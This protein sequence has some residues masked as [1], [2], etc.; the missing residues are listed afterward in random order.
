MSTKFN[1]DVCKAGFNSKYNLERHAGTGKC[2][3]NLRELIAVRSPSIQKGY[4]TPVDHVLSRIPNKTE[5]KRVI[6]DT[7]TPYRRKLE[8]GALTKDNLQKTWNFN[9][10]DIISKLYIKADWSDTS[11]LELSYGNSVILREYFPTLYQLYRPFRE[12]H[13]CI[14]LIRLL[15]FYNTSEFAIC[16]TDLKL[17]IINSYGDTD[18]IEYET[19]LLMLSENERK[20]L[21]Y[22]A[23]EIFIYQ[24]ELLRLQPT[25]IEIHPACNI[26]DSCLSA[27]ISTRFPTSAIY[28]IYSPKK[29]SKKQSLKD[30]HYANFGSYDL[31]N[32]TSPFYQLP[33]SNADQD[34]FLF[35]TKSSCSQVD[36]WNSLLP[37]GEYDVKCK[38]GSII[39]KY[40]TTLQIENG[41][42]YLFDGLTEEPVKVKL[43]KQVI[44][45]YPPQQSKYQDCDFILTEIF[46]KF[47]QDNIYWENNW[48]SETPSN[49][50]FPVPIPTP[51][52]VSNDFI[53]LLEGLLP[54]IIG[55]QLLCMD[56][57]CKFTNETIKSYCGYDP[58]TKYS[59]THK[60]Q[61]YAF[62]GTLLHEYIVLGIQPTLKFY[63]AVVEKSNVLRGSSNSTGN[64]LL[65]EIFPEYK[66]IDVEFAICDQWQD[67]KWLEVVVKQIF[68]VKVNDKGIAEIPHNYGISRITASDVILILFDVQTYLTPDHVGKDITI[69]NN[70]SHKF[71]DNSYI[72]ASCIRIQAGTADTIVNIHT[73]RPMQLYVK[74][75]NAGMT[76]TE[77]VNNEAVK[78]WY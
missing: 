75:E 48:F 74:S 18:Q 4:N 23:R 7:F 25:T 22:C 31:V 66:D 59:F 58:N 6:I 37:K 28:N 19:E 43:Y 57:V 41:A 73:L 51:T 29:Q 61:K 10:G 21:I 1:C 76:P 78:S 32:G 8:R 35:T 56:E 54:K 45:D 40:V 36:E 69:D 30:C 34:M 33:P 17:K 53:I 47:D 62:Y 38:D 16:A 24:Y 12:T 55:E 11:I 39:V 64:N 77:W 15:L 49:C 13:E 70:L 14:D 3:K 71:D 65:K 46:N 20:K 2:N 63:R 50:N 52:K 5:F 27:K 72:R 60:D 67:D 26:S 68:T 42:T 44:K 9:D